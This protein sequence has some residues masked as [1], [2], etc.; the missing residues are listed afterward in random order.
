[1]SSR[2]L[3]DL[4]STYFPTF[5]IFLFA[6]CYSLFNPQAPLPTQAISCE[7]KDQAILVTIYLMIE[8]DRELVSWHRCLLTLTF[9]LHFSFFLSSLSD[10]HHSKPS[11]VTSSRKPPWWSKGAV[12]IWYFHLGHMLGTVMAI[13][14]SQLNGKSLNAGLRVLLRYHIALVQ[15]FRNSRGREDANS[16]RFQ[17]LTKIGS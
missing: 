15:P 3:S 2:A 17:N 4:A 10:C 9:S 1:M 5:P 12:V 13:S 7:G 16:Y 8:M 6:H 14:R 11:L